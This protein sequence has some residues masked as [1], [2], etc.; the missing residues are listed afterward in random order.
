MPRHTFE[1][2][3]YPFHAIFQGNPRSWGPVG[4]NT[5]RYRHTKFQVP[6][7]AAAAT[8]AAAISTPPN[9][10]QTSSSE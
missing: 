6:A 3:L 5:A 2:G 8:A 4:A 1:T 7:P 10:T 9:I